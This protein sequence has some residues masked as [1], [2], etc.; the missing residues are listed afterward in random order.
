MTMS[1]ITRTVRSLILSS[2]RGICITLS[3]VG[4][5]FWT[6][7]FFI[8]YNT[9]MSMKMPSTTISTPTQA[10]NASAPLRQAL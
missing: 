5:S 7:R 2:G 3:T 4:R 8:G 10:K 1:A 6:E 9:A